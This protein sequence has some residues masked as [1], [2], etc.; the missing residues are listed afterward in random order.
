MSKSFSKK[1]SY[2]EE[3]PIFVRK[4]I[5]RLPNGRFAKK[6]VSDEDIE[7]FDD[8]FRL[9]FIAILVGIILGII[10]TSIF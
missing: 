7:I 9:V 2:Y 1:F 3:T 8:W 4:N 5:K 6:I 10:I